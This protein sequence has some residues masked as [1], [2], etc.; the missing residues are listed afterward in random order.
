[1]EFRP[2][3]S[4]ELKLMDQRL[5]FPEHVGF[6]QELAVKPRQNLPKRLQDT[7]L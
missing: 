6:E 7:S 2:Q 3:I 5:F 4:P 1:M